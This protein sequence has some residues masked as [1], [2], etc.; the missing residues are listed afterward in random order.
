MVDLNIGDHVLAYDVMHNKLVYSPVILFT[1]RNSDV[2]TTF[3]SV[4]TADNRHLL[5]TEN[6]LI[7][8]VKNNAGTRQGNSSDAN[9]GAKAI[10]ETILA[11]SLQTGNNLITVPLSSY[12]FTVSNS[13]IIHL[14]SAQRKG[15][16]APVTHIGTIVVD[17][18][19]VS[20]Y[21]EIAAHNHVHSVFALFRLFYDVLSYFTQNDVNAPSPI[22]IMNNSE[23]LMSAPPV[24]YIQ[25]T[26]DICYWLI[27]RVCKP[28]T[29][30]DLYVSLSF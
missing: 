26:F 3:R 28:T 17:D 9:K 12:D 4:R 13:A 15:V 1:H 10:V 29:F 11:G 18:V 19:V 2:T 30:V 27:A 14:N 20:C 23:V 5:L 21:C 16:Y 24:S 22:A 7:P 6:H 25:T 8:V